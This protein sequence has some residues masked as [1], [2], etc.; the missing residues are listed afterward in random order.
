MLGLRSTRSLLAGVARAGS[1]AAV[2]LAF[3]GCG[4][5]FA[6]SMNGSP[7]AAAYESTPDLGAAPASDL[8][9]GAETI[10]LTNPAPLASDV[11]GATTFDF[12]A[13]LGNAPDRLEAGITITPRGTLTPLAGAFSWKSYSAGYKLSF[14]PSAPLTDANDFVISVA[15]PRSTFAP[16]LLHTG[17]STGSHPRVTAV[18]LHAAGAGAGVYFTFTFSEPMSTPAVIASVSVTAGGQ[19]ASGHALLDAANSQ[20]GYRFDLDAGH[21]LPAPIVLRIAAGP[22]GA[23]ALT[24]VALDPAS[25]D[26]PTAASDGSFQVI[27]SSVDLAAPGAIDL[28]WAPT[29]N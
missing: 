10:A 11:L 23:T 9:F 8:G 14:I 25:W 26:S 2:A 5:D 13:M 12:D 24:G 21:P 7:D 1:I 6:Y 18:T 27:F 19:A 17:I 3:L 28:S 29:I 4:G 16:P 20:G 22:G 15:D